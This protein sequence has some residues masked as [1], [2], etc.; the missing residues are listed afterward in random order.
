MSADCAILNSGTLRAD[1]VY[2]PG[3]L[4][5]GDFNDINPFR[6]E[7]D[8][9]EVTGSQLIEL[10]ENGVSCYPTLEGRFPMVSNIEFEFDPTKP[11]F[12][13]IVPG[14]IKV[15]GLPLLKSMYYRVASVTYLT[16]GKDG[17]DAFKEGRPLIDIETAVVLGDMMTNFFD[18]A[19]SRKYREEFDVYSS[20]MEIITKNVIRERIRQKVE[21]DA[22]LKSKLRIKLQLI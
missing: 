15:A 2:S 17:Y 11:A 3:F 6:K 12:S 16:S 21:K 8:M 18:L 9:V 19:E 13:R 4:T 7:V 20:N 5:V 10:L 1:R 14:I 22:H